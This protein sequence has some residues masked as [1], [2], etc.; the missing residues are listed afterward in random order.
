MNHFQTDGEVCTSWW[1]VRGANKLSTPVPKC[2]AL[3]HTQNMVQPE[4]KLLSC[5]EP[6][7]PGPSFTAT[8]FVTSG[9]FLTLSDQL[10]TYWFWSKLPVVVF[11]LTAP[12][13]AAGVGT[14]SPPRPRWPLA[15]LL[16]LHSRDLLWQRAE[17]QAAS[18]KITQEQPQCIT[19]G[20]EVTRVYHNH[21]FLLLT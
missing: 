19:S 2:D 20:S 9:F 8:G 5:H 10:S 3:W 13:L 11:S 6:L 1:A 14:L 4:G 12:V 18:T 15:V 17:T 21:C 16:S 7:I